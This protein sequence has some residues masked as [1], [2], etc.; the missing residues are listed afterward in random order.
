M[1]RLSLMIFVIL[2]GMITPVAADL[3]IEDLNIGY[4]IEELLQPVS[5]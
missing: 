1:K 4:S 3:D 2:L 5:P